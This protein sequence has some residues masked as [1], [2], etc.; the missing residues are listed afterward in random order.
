MEISNIFNN[1]FASIFQPISPVLSNDKS[2]FKKYLHNSPSN[3]FFFLNTDNSEVTSIIK[4]FLNTPSSGDDN[5]LNI[6]LKSILSNI[7]VPLTHLVNLS[8]TS[9]TFPSIFK[10]SKIKPIFKTGCHLECCNYR[11]I[12]LLPTISKIIEK[13]VHTRLY[14]FIEKKTYFHRASMDS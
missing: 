5:I 13:I 11:P 2:A 9:G 3:S 6:L 7:I 8:L 10:L 12:S 1:H 14:S 4:S